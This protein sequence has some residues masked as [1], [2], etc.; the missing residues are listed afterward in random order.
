MSFLS[1]NYLFFILLS[2][3]LY[4]LLPHKW[5]KY[6]L[7]LASLAF[8]YL[9]NHILLICIILSILSVYFGAIL[10]QKYKQKRKLIFIL[11]ICFNLLFLIGFKY[12]NFYLGIYN[13]VSNKNISFTN[14]IIPLGLSYYT[15]EALSYLI[16]VYN[17]KYNMD[18]NIINVA[19]YLLYFPLLIEG[20]I[21]RYNDLKD[22]FSENHKFIYKQFINSLVLIGFGLLKK[23]VIADRAA[24]YVNN[25]FNKNYTGTAVLVAIILYTLEIYAD[26]SGCMDIVMGISELFGIK[27]KANFRQPFFSKTINEFWT[28]WHITLGTWLKDYIF[29]PLSISKLNQ[30]IGLNLRRKKHPLIARFITIAIPLF[31]VWLIMGLWHGPTLKYILYGMYY[32]IIMILGILLKPLEV[33]LMKLLKINM[34]VFSF[35]LFQMFRTTLLVMIG[36]LI[37]TSNSLLD[38][39]N[40]LISIFKANVVQITSLGLN[41]ADFRLLI[42]MIFILLII[43][44]MKEL[45][46]DIREKLQEQNL[47]FRWLIYLIL[48]FSIIIFG[49]Y[50]TGY[51]PANFIY[52]G[53]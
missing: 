45:G 14:I 5:Q 18:N 4:Y 37:F 2:L 33:K 12:S 3:F 36:M 46:T 31:F 11:T 32:Y 25:V 6:I 35:K 48:I 44:Y 1:I 52:G 47:P 22:Q 27:L 26:F 49:M 43:G 24:I 19:L 20:P 7:L 40:T 21:S 50:G 17:N 51:N 10:I 30:K 39:Y 53:F 38:A 42:I 29:Y 23:L 41:K 8:Y 9:N 16:D 34:Q 13:I 28:R 15:L